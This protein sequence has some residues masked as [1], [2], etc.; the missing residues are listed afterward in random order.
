MRAAVP[1][2]RSPGVDD[3]HA[4]QTNEI[5]AIRS[6][7]RLPAKAASVDL[8]IPQ[9]PPKHC[10][11]PRHVLTLRT[12]EFAR[13]LAERR[14]LVHLV[15]LSRAGGPGLREWSAFVPAVALHDRQP[16]P[17]SSRPARHTPSVAFGDTFPASRRRG[18]APAATTTR[19][20]RPP[21]RWRGRGAA[22]RATSG[23]STI[24]GWMIRAEDPFSRLR[25]KVPAR[26]AAG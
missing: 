21:R 1:P 5:R 19:S 6:D 7:W 22:P 10:L 24:G 25:E 8:M 17:P 12:R 26:R 14:R 15:Y 13:G 3:E 9:S 16:K 23:S 20:T 11:R 18:N 4:G 2:D